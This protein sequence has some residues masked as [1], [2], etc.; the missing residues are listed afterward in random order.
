MPLID[1]MTSHAHTALVVLV[2]IVS[3]PW[4]PVEFFGEWNAMYVISAPM[5]CFAAL[6]HQKAQRAA[7]GQRW[8]EWGPL[9]LSRGLEVPPR[10]LML[11]EM[12]CLY[13]LSFHYVVFVLHFLSN[14]TGTMPS[15]VVTDA[16]QHASLMVRSTIGTS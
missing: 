15:S 7:G 10:S 1:T 14:F 13:V 5:R 6:V 4:W 9:Q 12:V 16:W 11:R 3:A 2:I 8:P